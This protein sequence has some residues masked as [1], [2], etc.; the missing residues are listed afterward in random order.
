MISAREKVKYW[1]VNFSSDEVLRIKFGTS[2]HI[3]RIDK[4]A[5]MKIGDRIWVRETWDAVADPAATPQCAWKL[6]RD[7]G[8]QV[9]IENYE[10]ERGLTPV[11]IDYKADNPTRIMDKPHPRKTMRHWRSPVCMPRSASRFTLEITNIIKARLNDISPKN[12]VPLSIKYREINPVVSS[13]NFKVI[14]EH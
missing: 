4:F 12:Y 2:M 10:F 9:S 8:E 3:W 14:D 11:V 5:K 1:P 13:I 7:S 6:E